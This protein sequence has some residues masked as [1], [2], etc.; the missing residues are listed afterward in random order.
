M[1]DTNLKANI[2]THELKLDNGDVVVFYDYLTTG[3]SRELQKL[4]LA[5][6]EFNSET[7]KIENLAAASFLDI[8]DKSTE[9]VVKE[10]RIQEA[11]ATPFSQ[12]WLNGLPVTLGNAVYEEVNTI[13]QTSQLPKDEKKN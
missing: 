4:L 1:A 10:V 3:E 2:P 13:T 8:Q 9:I 11:E 6:G 7:A 5:S 12:D